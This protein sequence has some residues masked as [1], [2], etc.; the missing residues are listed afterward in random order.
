MRADRPIVIDGGIRINRGTLRGAAILGDWENDGVTDTNV[1]LNYGVMYSDRRFSALRAEK[2]STP[3]RVLA[4]CSRVLRAHASMNISLASAHSGQTQP[5]GR[6]LNKV[7]G[8]T[9]A[10]GSPS[11]GTYS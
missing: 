5:S 6:S 2:P 8:A 3:L 1:M 4:A 9:S 11:S 7:P 10:S